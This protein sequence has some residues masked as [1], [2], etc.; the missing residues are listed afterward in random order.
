MMR[1]N[2]VLPLALAGASAMQPAAAADLSVSVQTAAGA[3]IE[4]AI[5]YAVPAV[6]VHAAPGTR[7]LVDQVDRKFV[8]RV[9]VVQSG[10]SVAFPNSDNIRH[11]VYSFSPVK[12]FTLKLYA[13]KSTDPIVFDKSGLVVLGCNIHD[14][15]VAWLLVVD[16]PYFAH[17]DHGGVATLP[18]LPPGEYTL[19]AWHSPMTE[20]QQV[21]ETLHV[22]AGGASVA[23]TLHISVPVDPPDAAAKPK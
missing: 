23:R 9:S 19:N 2:S 21:S 4:D 7:Y 18:K 10:T 20:D 3:P 17:T 6:T 8:P 11:S 5:V 13:G 1:W 16:T 14:T 15:M 22:D 12:V